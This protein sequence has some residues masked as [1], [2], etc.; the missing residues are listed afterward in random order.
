MRQQRGIFV[1]GRK[2]LAETLELAEV[3]SQ[4]L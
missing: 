4:S 1:F 3:G 2:D